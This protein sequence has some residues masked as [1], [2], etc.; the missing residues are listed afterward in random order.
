MA[1]IQRSTKLSLRQEEYRICSE[2]YVFY[3]LI[4]DAN[5]VRLMTATASEDTGDYRAYED[6]GALISATAQVLSD[7]EMD[8]VTKRDHA[9][10]PYIETSV[11]P[12]SEDLLHLASTILNR[13]GFEDISVLALREMMAIYNEFAIDDSGEDTY[14]SDGM[15]MT[16]DG[17]LIEK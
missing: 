11:Y 4:S 16:S 3:R 6:Q 14:L 2:P 7:R 12:D 8:F 15:W 13:I 10:R 9:N 17:R 1:I 5:G